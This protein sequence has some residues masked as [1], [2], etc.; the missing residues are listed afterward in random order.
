MKKQKW[1][2]D[3][4]IILTGASSGM[5][6]DLVKMLIT[7]Y[8]CNVLGIAR[9]KEKME[10]LQA[11]LGEY[12]KNFTYQLFDVSIEQNWHDL[13]EKLG[14]LNFA[15]DVLINCAGVLP[16][17]QTFE[18]QS[19]DQ[20]TQTMNIN[21]FACVY[22]C[23]ILYDEIMKSKT[24]AFIN[25]ASSASLCSLPGITAYTASKSALKN[26]TESFREEMVKKAY[27]TLICPG[28]VK[29]DI[30]RSQENYE[31]SK[32]ID[33]ISMDCDKMTKK[34]VKSIVKKKRRV[35]LG[36]DAKAMDR[37]YRWMPKTSL[38]IL[39]KVLKASKINLFKDVYD[40]NDK[41]SKK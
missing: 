31:G 36:M 39:R 15:P 18:K 4:N 19:L 14:E 6:K 37:L 25:I 40:Y 21:F 26:F 17:F 30:M 5:G 24:P 10:K 13:K 3:K 2:Q 38:V 27:V 28:F 29:T 11:E 1:I 7:K 35:V 12:S 22:A 20:L 9:S 33:F 8:N 16:P 32:L 23:K 34:I 41:K